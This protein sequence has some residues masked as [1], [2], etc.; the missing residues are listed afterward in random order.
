MPKQPS[1]SRVNGSR[2]AEDRGEIVVAALKRLVGYG[3]NPLDWSVPFAKAFG[4]VFRVHLVFLFYVL[5]KLIW[6]VSRDKVGLAFT[7]PLMASLFVVVLAHEL[8]HVA[9]CRRLGGRATRVI[10]WP[11]GGFAEHDVPDHWRHTLMTALAGPLVNVVMWVGLSTALYIATDNL[12]TVFFTP[13]EAL[14]TLLSDVTLPGGESPRWLLVLW[15]LHYVNT[16]LILF[17]LLLPML[18]MD[19]GRGL[20]A[21]LWSFMG[22]SPALEVTSVVG[23]VCGG[24]LGVFAVAGE[25]TALLVIAGLGI[26][27]CYQEHKRLAFLRTGGEDRPAL[28][29][30]RHPR[31][32][33]LLSDDPHDGM[34]FGEIDEGEEPEPE[35]D[36]RDLE[37]AEVDRILAK[38]SSEGMDALTPR[39]RET[40]K[41]ASEPG[42]E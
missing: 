8:G 39:E 40:L 15:S 23:I 31:P 18:P 27:V 22:R 17:N 9:A 3:E 28:R 20:H 42:A 14:P 29:T 36:P 35:P 13:Y 32:T 2:P 24:A 6:S 25:E 26:W 16:I 19:A 41:R 21:V 37:R 4:V 7:V 10:M 1:K 34:E 12:H 30:E 33:D 38:I 11:L 5:S